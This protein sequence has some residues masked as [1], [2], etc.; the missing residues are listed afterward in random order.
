MPKKEFM[1]ANAFERIELM[2]I[3]FPV[4]DYETTLATFQSWIE[5]KPRTPHQ[6]CTVN[7]HSLMTCQHH[8]QLKQTMRN[9]SL[10]TMDGHPLRW[11]ANIKYRLNIRDRVC[12]PDLMQKC[13]AASERQGWRHFLIGGTP[14]VLNQLVERLSSRFPHA[15][16][17]GHYSPPFRPLTAAETEPVISHI[18]HAKPDFLWVGLGA[19]KQELWINFHLKDIK[20]P[21]Q[22]GVGAAFDFLSGNIPRAPQRYQKL[23]LEWLY[24]TLKDPKRLWS[25]YLLT[26]SQFILQAAVELAKY[27]LRT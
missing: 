14:Q 2:G 18:N 15:K 17:V 23:G 10:L 4:L 11:L 27:R 25:R 8:R 1:N 13:F 5:E 6:V 21:V 16:I 20:V 19:P 7:T 24:R 22:I 9:A 26:N 3:E 12:G